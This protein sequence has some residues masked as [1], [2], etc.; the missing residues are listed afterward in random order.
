MILP[1]EAHQC[2]L[3]LH[4][5]CVKTTEMAYLAQFCLYQKMLENRP[6]LKLKINATSLPDIFQSE[7]N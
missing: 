6:P 3:V 1:S 4:E 7:L 2:D 5:V